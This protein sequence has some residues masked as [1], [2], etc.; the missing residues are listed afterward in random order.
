MASI[1]F[2][3]DEDIFGIVAPALRQHGYDAVSTPEVGRLAES[4]D[5]QLRWASEERRCIITFKMCCD[6]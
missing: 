3:T 1:R 2:F 4:D 5:S 6:V